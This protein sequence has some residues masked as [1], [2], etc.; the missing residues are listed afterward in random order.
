[1]GVAAHCG[2]IG[3]VGKQAE[4]ML[5]YSPYK[6]HLHTLN[7]ESVSIHERERGGGGHTMSLV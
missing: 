6:Q 1:M 2:C 3:V 5:H 4:Y 7:K